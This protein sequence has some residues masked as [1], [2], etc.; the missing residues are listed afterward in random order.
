MQLAEYW[1]KRR[2]SGRQLELRVSLAVWAALLAAAAP[3]YTKDIPTLFLMAAAG[4]LILLHG[5]FISITW[6]SSGK[7]IRLADYL[8]RKPNDSHQLNST[9]NLLKKRTK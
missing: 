7:Q 8:S 5:Y 9:Q 4:V 6:Q 2:E 3:T 1:R